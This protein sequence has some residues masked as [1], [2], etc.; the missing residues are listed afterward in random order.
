MS[1]AFFC[2][3]EDGYVYHP[4]TP[5]SLPDIVYHIE[6]S[7]SRETDSNVWYTA[8]LQDRHR[9]RVPGNVLEWHGIECQIEPEDGFVKRDEAKELGLTEDGIVLV[10][11]I[12]GK[13]GKP[14]TWKYP[15]ARHDGHAWAQLMAY[16][17]DL[18]A[19][20]THDAVK[21]CRPRRLA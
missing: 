17:R 4:A 3:C 10:A 9:Q 12:K 2:I 16:L 19:L 1:A 11:H 5:I 21:R 18:A 20:G 7:F 8:Y 14:L 13:R 15:N 6:T